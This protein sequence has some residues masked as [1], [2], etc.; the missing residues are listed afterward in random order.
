MAKDS[1]IC[2][3]HN[4]GGNPDHY[5]PKPEL[6][7]CGVDCSSGTFDGCHNRCPWLLAY[8]PVGRAVVNGELVRP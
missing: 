1:D 8:P 6:V 2:L 5:C 3:Y 4:D 7:E